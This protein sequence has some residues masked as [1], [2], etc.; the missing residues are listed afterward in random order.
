MNSIIKLDIYY[1]YLEQ[2]Q[3]RN[4]EDIKEFNKAGSVNYSQVRQKKIDRIFGVRLNL[5]HCYKNQ[6]YLSDCFLY[7][8]LIIQK[9]IC[10]AHM[11]KYYFYS[12][13]SLGLIIFLC[14]PQYL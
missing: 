8:I 12:L 4:K 14:E 11:I 9:K 5:S 13:N 1:I 3:D 6:W 7:L 2:R 10:R